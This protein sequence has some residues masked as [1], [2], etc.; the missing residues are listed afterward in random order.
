M[1]LVLGKYICCNR[2]LIDD[3]SSF[4]WAWDFSSYI[5]STHLNDIFT[6]SLTINS[7]K[8]HFLN[9]FGLGYINPSLTLTLILL[10]HF[11]MAF[12]IYNRNACI[13]LYM[14]VIA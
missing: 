8:L 7:T 2:L 14:Y 11:E 1:L 12:S 3:G 5:F 9:Y 6:H 10:Y 4:L 13:T